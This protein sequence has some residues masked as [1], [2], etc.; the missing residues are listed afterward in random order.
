VRAQ[1]EQVASRQLDLA[2][3]SESATHQPVVC[4]MLTPPQPFDHYACSPSTS[5]P[6][7]W[8]VL[9]EAPPSEAGSNQ[10]NS[11]SHPQP[12]AGMS[13]CPFFNH[14]GSRKLQPARSVQVS[15][16][17]GP[18]NKLSLS[19]DPPQSGSKRT[20]AGSDAGK[21]QVDVG[22]S[23]NPCLPARPHARLPAW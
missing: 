19:M 16:L 15:S 11:Q 6:E 7:G 23:W 1:P 8:A 5:I 18:Y 3:S 4:L 21:K 2:A 9:G 22:A 12:S 14:S 17:N 13:G 10:P 20:T